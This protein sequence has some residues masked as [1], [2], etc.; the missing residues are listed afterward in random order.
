MC[1]KYIVKYKYVNQNHQDFVR[2]TNRHKDCIKNQHRKCFSVIR[3]I[4]IS[5]LYNT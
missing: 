2:C 3:H 5:K 4:V 1:N